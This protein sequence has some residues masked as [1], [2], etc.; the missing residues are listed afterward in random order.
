MCYPNESNQ[1]ETK[2]G[3]N[4]RMALVLR[5]SVKSRLHRCGACMCR[6]MI[7]K[8]HPS[9]KEE[10]VHTHMFYVGAVW[11]KCSTDA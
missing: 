9:L 1:G 11:S 3:A 2:L 8:R 5:L 7:L 6:G 4:T 10:K